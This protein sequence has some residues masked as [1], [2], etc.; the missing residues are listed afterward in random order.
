[1]R[2]E[3]L[4]FSFD[5]PNEMIEDYR[6]DFEEFKDPTMREELNIIRESL[7]DMLMLVELEPKILD[8]SDHVMKFAEALAMKQ[9][10]TDLKL[11]HDA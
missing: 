4:D 11:L 8:K 3:F 1:M 10:L 7:Y 9:A 2:F 6:S 5:I